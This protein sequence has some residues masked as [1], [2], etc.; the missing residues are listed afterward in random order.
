MNKKD[1]LCLIVMT[2]S[3]AIHYGRT[4]FKRNLFLSFRIPDR[5]ED[6]LDPESRSLLTPYYLRIFALPNFPT[7]LF[8]SSY[9]Y[10]S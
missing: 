6:K 4:V 8:S 9:E 2:S 5:V 1:I 3:T 7:S 10:D